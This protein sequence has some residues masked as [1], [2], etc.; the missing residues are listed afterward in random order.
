M[1][2]KLLMSPFMR[3]LQHLFSFMNAQEQ[4]EHHLGLANAKVPPS[5]GVE[6]ERQYPLRMFVQDVELWGLATD[7]P[8]ARQGPA[9]ALR[10]TGHAREMIREMPPQLLAFGQE[11]ADAAG[12]IIGRRT[13]VECFLRAL[14][15]RYG[16]LDQEIQIFNVSELMTFAR[17]SGE[18][19][20]QMI[21]RF[22][23]IMHR[24]TQLGGV[25]AFDPVV[26]SW[27]LLTHLKVPRNTWPMLLAPTL[28]ML[29]VNE[30]QY[31]A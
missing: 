30:V 13:G 6:K 27:I 26:R 2:I 21:T 10:L 19:T 22:D 14:N 24:A 23:I 1:T 25:P 28:G 9:L 29:P 16:A 3:V 7:L 5:W 11:I 31:S 20:D 8:E 15:T 17:R 18:S 4:A 12:N